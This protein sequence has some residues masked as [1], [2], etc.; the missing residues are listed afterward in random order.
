MNGRNYLDQR[1]QLSSD[2]TS[3][4]GCRRLATGAFAQMRRCHAACLVGLRHA[5]LL[6]SK[7]SLS[8]A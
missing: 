5:L 7:Q 6:S 1:R 2:W 8:A 4:P 3:D